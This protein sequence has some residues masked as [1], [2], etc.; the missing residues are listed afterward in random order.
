MILVFWMLSLKPAF[1][2]S[3]FSFI[4][5]LFSSSSLSALRVMSSAYLR[6]LIFLPSI[7]IPACDSSSPVF[8]M[9]HS[10]CKLNNQDDN[11]QP[12]HTPSP[13]LNQSTVPC[14]VLT[15]ASWP[16]YSFLRRQVRW[17]GVLVSLRI[18]HSLLWPTHSLSCI[19]EGNVNPLQWSCLENPRDRGAWWAAVYGVA[20]VGHNG[21]DLAAAAA[22]AA[23]IQRL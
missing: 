16:A 13:V 10:T 11:V 20:R 9:M 19:G 1:L 17:S 4:K 12:W 21:S 3:S 18:F 15:V 6:L 8:H 22:A 23:H 14:P 5:R 7:L 2:L